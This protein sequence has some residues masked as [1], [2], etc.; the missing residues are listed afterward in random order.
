MDTG[1][2]AES[3]SRLQ[4]ETAHKVYSEDRTPENRAEYLRALRVFS[5]IVMNRRAEPQGPNPRLSTQ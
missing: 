2:I 1:E 4:L 5:D 3:Q